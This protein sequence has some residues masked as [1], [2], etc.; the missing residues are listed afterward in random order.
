VKRQSGASGPASNDLHHTEAWIVSGV[1][2]MGAVVDGDERRTLRKIK[3]L[4]ELLFWESHVI[5][6]PSSKILSALHTKLAAETEQ[7]LEFFWKNIETD[8]LARVC[9]GMMVD[10]GLVGTDHPALKATLFSLSQTYHEQLPF[11]ALDAAHATWKFWERPTS[12]LNLDVSPRF[13][14]HLLPRTLADEYALTH[15]IF[16]STDFGRSPEALD[17][18]AKELEKRLG[19]LAAEAW[20]SGNLDIL[21]EHLLCLR[22]IGREKSID[23]DFFSHE[24]LNQRVDNCYWQGPL[25]LKRKLLSEGFKQGQ[26][27]FFENYHTTLLVRDVLL[28]QAHG[29]Q[30]VREN[31]RRASSG[32]TSFDSRKIGTLDSLLYLNKF[33]SATFC[34][35]LA[36]PEY[37]QMN[38]LALSRWVRHCDNASKMLSASLKSF[39]GAIADIQHKPRDYS[40]ALTVALAQSL[41]NEFYDCAPAVGRLHIPNRIEKASIKLMTEPLVGAGS[42]RKFGSKTEALCIALLRLDRAK[43][44]SFWLT[45]LN[46]LLHRAVRQRDVINMAYLLW[47]A[48]TAGLTVDSDIAAHGRNLVDFYLSQPPESAL[49]LRAARM[50]QVLLAD[51]Q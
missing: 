6:Q 40:L 3:C 8:T 2:S 22:F 18:R 50:G 7:L 19:L 10:F 49:L 14:G 34:E 12:K 29:R 31:Y 47:A 38:L 35:E 28:G 21:A 1:L 36:D 30:L 37:I 23:I 26:L 17:N 16:Y 42:E 43:I 27:Q 41:R 45:A 15:T 25:Q 46:G 13:K 9:L 4:V 51:L 24:L 39:I 44:S 5:S 20:A 33:C 11:R 48:D 32:L